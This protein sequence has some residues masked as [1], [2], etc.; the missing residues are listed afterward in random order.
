MING[1]LTV[2]EISLEWG[3]T[4]RRIQILCS[5]GRI[6]GAERVGKMW[7]IPKGT[8]KPKDARETTGAYKSK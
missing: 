6:E 8:D 5:E 1:Y 3:I 2:K 4:P 7:L